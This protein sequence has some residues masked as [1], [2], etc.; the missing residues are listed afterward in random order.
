MRYAF[1]DTETTGLDPG[2]H[3]MW[4]LAIITREE[5][6]PRDEDQEHLFQVYPGRLADADPT[7]LRINRFYDRISPILQTRQAGAVRAVGVSADD[8]EGG[9]VTMHRAKAALEIASLLNGALIIASNPTFDAAMYGR[10]MISKFLRTWGEV[11]GW[12]YHLIDIRTLAL[13]YLCGPGVLPDLRMKS[14]TLWEEIGLTPSNYAT[15][16]ALSDARLVRDV[17]DT[18]VR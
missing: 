16:S 2:R 10:G 12:D 8:T 9:W 5:G 13:G 3:E 15:H 11:E 6:H 14:A 17:F 4:E 18:I 7:A 1:L